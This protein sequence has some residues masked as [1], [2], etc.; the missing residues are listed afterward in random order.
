MR[1][2]VAAFNFERRG[3]S[4]QRQVSVNAFWMSTPESLIM[5][6][7]KESDDKS[8][9]SKVHRNR[10]FLTAPCPDPD[11]AAEM[12]AAFLRV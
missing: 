12:P 11:H 7:E 2:L 10:E 6:P 4:E 8:S 3:R 1:R 9:H 5:L